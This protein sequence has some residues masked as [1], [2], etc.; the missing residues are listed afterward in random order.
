[1]LDVEEDNDVVVGAAD[2]LVSTLNGAWMAHASGTKPMYVAA[3][4]L[5]GCLETNG[6]ALKMAIKR[7]AKQ[8]ANAIVKRNFY[9]KEIES[10]GWQTEKGMCL[11]MDAA[12]TR[13]IASMRGSNR[14]ADRTTS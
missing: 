3:H 4:L 11:V 6:P 8:L 9:E 1:M 13:L 12:T 10:M 7:N 5:V 14:L 2:E